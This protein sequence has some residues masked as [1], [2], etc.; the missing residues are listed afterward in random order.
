MEGRIWVDVVILSMSSSYLSHMRVCK[1]CNMFY[2]LHIMMGAFVFQDK[3]TIRNQ[4]PEEGQL[5]QAGAG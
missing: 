3:L 2:V 1:I 5:R 4:L